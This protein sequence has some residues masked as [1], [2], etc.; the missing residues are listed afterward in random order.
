MSD[1]IRRR[2]TVTTTQS[3]AAQPASAATAPVLKDHLAVGPVGS[4]A[5][6]SSASSV[7]QPVRT[8]R[9][10][11]PASTTDTT[12]TDASWSQPE[13]VRV[14]AVVS[15]PAAMRLRTMSRKYFGSVS[16][17]AKNL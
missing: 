6:A 4:Q 2:R 15:F 14:L 12:S 11:R 13:H 1:L 10:H 16:S 17:D 9:S 8:R 3:S 5:P 7:E